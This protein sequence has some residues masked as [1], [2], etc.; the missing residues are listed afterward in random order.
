MDRNSESGEKKAKLQ[1]CYTGF[2]IF[3][4]PKHG[5]RKVNLILNN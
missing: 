1:Q 4:S 5:K 2:Q 3:N